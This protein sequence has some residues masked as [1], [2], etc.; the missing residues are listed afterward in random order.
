MKIAD[1]IV[2][3][4]VPIQD[5]YM[6]PTLTWDDTHLV[7]IDTGYAKASE[8][9]EQAIMDAGFKPEDLTD[10]IITHQDWDHIGGLT[11]L[12]K[13]APT[14]NVLAHEEETPYIEQEKMPVKLAGMLEIYDTLPP[15]RKAWCDKMEDFFDNFSVTITDT[16]TDGEVLPYCGGIEV[17]FTP[18][19]TPGHICLFLQS[20]KIMVSGDAVNF[21]NGELKNANP[22]MTFD[23]NLAEKSFEK[24]KSYDMNGLLSYHCGYL[25]LK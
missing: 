11:E 23:M 4:E 19:H 22:S 20:S 7:L 3:L 12:L 18:G 1:N 2:M 15:D 25:K 16:L 13:L 17:V 10:I 8:G 5:M 6:Y 21:E 14:A 24:I 9:I